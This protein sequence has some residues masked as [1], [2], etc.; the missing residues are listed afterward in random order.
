MS[1][2]HPEFERRR[3]EMSEAM[4]PILGHQRAALGADRFARFVQGHAELQAMILFQVMSA[5]TVPQTGYSD[6]ALA[7]FKQDARDVRKAA[8]DWARLC[9]QLA[10]HWRAQRQEHGASRK[11][12]PQEKEED[13][14]ETEA[15]P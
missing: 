9:E 1:D 7:A 4:S 15:G 8:A 2:L 10:D 12:E 13:D 14:G 5:M 11:E 3:N 6:D